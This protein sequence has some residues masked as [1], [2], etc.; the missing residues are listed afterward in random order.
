MNKSLQNA[1]NPLNDNGVEC[2]NT[3]L[4]GNK[5]LNINDKAGRYHMDLQLKPRDA[6]TMTTPGGTSMARKGEVEKLMSGGSARV[7]R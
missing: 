4:G 6:I 2:K 7:Q 5:N 3:L 1:F